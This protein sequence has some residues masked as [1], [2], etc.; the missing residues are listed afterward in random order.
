MEDTRGP[1]VVGL[2]GS[3]SSRDALRWAAH[4]AAVRSA[5]LHALYAA[6]SAEPE[7]WAA[8]R[9]M[10][11]DAVAEA[12][13]LCPDSPV[14]GDVIDGQPF[15]ELCAASTG[16]DMIVV[17]SRGLGGFDGLLVG[18]VSCQV[19]LHAGCSVTIVHPSRAPGARQGVAP[20]DPQTSP[21]SG[22]PGE[23][24]V[25]VG[26]DSSPESNKA[27]GVAF[28]EA[29]S[30]GTGVLAIR[31]WTPRYVSH[32]GTVYHSAVNWEQTNKAAQYAITEDLA[33]WRERYPHVPVET[34]FVAEGPA[35]ALTS[36]SAS[37]QLLVVGSRGHGDFTGPRLGATTYQ[38]L[39][40]ARCPVMII[41]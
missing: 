36:A 15:T 5:P 1:I 10:I 30:H 4:E 3:Q 17:A 40:H 21:E 12:R 11:A 31:A 35:S 28:R 27:I 22:A 26:T 29:D 6:G 8:A 7:L 14:S 23:P 25:L 34:R 18:S 19:A 39:H 24:P 2:D 16:A 20:G 41:R 38:L 37:A 9:A 32:R 13:T 33:P